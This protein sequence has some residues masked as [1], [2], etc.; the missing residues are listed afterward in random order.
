MSSYSKIK[1]KAT[2]YKMP[3]NDNNAPVYRVI[4]VDF[5]YHTENPMKSALEAVK[6]MLTVVKGDLK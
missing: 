1:A 6:R 5:K 2:L 3:C 4:P